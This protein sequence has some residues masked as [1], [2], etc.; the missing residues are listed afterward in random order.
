RVRRAAVPG[1]LKC[2]RRRVVVRKRPLSQDA[3]ERFVELPT[4]AE[5]ERDIRSYLPL[6]LN[7]RGDGPMARAGRLDDLE[8][9]LHGA[10]PVEQE[11]REG[12]GET[13]R[14]CGFRRIA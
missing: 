3:F 5:I 14:R 11:R 13:A 7:E 6:V 8:I 10:R 9:A 2:V 4:Q 12:V 1:D